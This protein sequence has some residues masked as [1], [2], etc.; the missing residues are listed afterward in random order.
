MSTTE[1][2]TFKSAADTLPSPPSQKQLSITGGRPMTKDQMK[3]CAAIMRNLKK[4]RDAAPFLNPVDYI[5]L[6]VPDYPQV[7][8]RP[9]DL[10]LID[11][12]LNQN[13]YVTVDDFVADVRL[14][15]NN[16]FKYNGPEAMISVLCQNV[17]SAFEK[18]LRQMPPS[19]DELSSPVSQ[20][21]PEDMMDYTS[22]ERPKR[23]IHVP[24]KDYPET[25]TTASS[26]VMKYCLQTV[27]ELKKQKYKHLSF[28]FLYP[29]DPV[30]LN[31]PD[32]PTI[33]KH[34]MDLS[35]IETKLNR[36]E[37]DSP[38]A[39][40]ADIKLMFDNCYLYNPPHLPI[41]DLAKQLQVIF[42]Q[43][44][45]QR[46]TEAIEEQPAKKRR[47]SKVN[48][49]N[50]DDVTIA[51][52]ERHIATISQQIESIK[53]SSSKKSPK[54]RTTRPS[55]A[56]K[57]AG[58]TPKKKKKR[59]TKYREMSSDEEDSGFTFEQK[60]QLSESIN[61]LTGDQ[62]NEV[63]DIIRSSMPN[64]DSVGEEEIELDIDSL[65]INTL[66]RLNNYVKSRNTVQ[67]GTPAKNRKGEEDSSSESDNN[68]NSSESSSDDSDSD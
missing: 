15:F 2:Q 45:A 25:F 29:V 40:A 27:K 8:K 7:I 62:L 65:D 58:T 21:A 66:T 9:I 59:M 47:I 38:D 48:R 31:I 49:V 67:K 11:Q 4:H 10:T 35:T 50:Q 19:L 1:N 6:N 33:V 51:E 18:G 46:P 42:D 43:K 20:Q 37:Y 68:N 16:C 53:S 13:E 24:S 63:V 64:L 39:F 22:Y 12:K 41:Y 61:N 34:P 56:K 3:Y 36:N 14:V 44:W 32:Y 60:R 17:E 28:P 54:K 30:A 52:L 5:K 23:E 26:K 55:P 57:E